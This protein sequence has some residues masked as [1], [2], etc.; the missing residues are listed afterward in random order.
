MTSIERTLVKGVSIRNVDDI[1]K[2]AFVRF[3]I[4]LNCKQMILKKMN[5]ILERDFY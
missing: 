3:V 2:N 1:F 4:E 5:E